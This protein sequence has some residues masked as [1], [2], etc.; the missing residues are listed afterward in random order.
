[1]EKKITISKMFLQKLLDYYLKEIY[2]KFAGYPIT[3]QT[4]DA[5]QIE[6]NNIMLFN[7]SREPLNQH[8]YIEPVIVFDKTTLKID[9]DVVSIENLNLV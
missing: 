6:L 1:M 7:R 9:V 4:L 3:S 2:I 8:W 5:M